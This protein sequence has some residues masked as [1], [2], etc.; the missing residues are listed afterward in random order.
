MTE[1]PLGKIESDA[2]EVFGVECIT[3]T[4]DF[5]CL[6]VDRLWLATEEFFQ[7]RI[8]IGLLA[9]GNRCVPAGPVVQ[10]AGLLRRHATVLDVPSDGFLSRQDAKV[11]RPAGMLDKLGDKVSTGKQLRAGQSDDPVDVLLLLLS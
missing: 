9:L 11:N 2:N 5:V 3:S 1:Q 8:K 4:K 7:G 6:V 10:E